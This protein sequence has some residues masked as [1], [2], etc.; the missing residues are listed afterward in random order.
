M[1]ID[2]R[3]LNFFIYFMNNVV[4]RFGVF[5]GFL[6]LLDL[7]WVFVLFKLFVG[8]NIFEVFVIGMIVLRIIEIVY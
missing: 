8:K 7:K 4:I 6:V 1:K 5:S 3:I 2:L